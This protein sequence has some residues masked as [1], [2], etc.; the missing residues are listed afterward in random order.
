MG[1]RSRLAG[2]GR[3]LGG[4]PRADGAGELHIGDPRFDDWEVVR[5]FEDL[6]AARAFSQ[7]LDERGLDS[8]LTADWP[9]DRF[10]RGDIA[11][12]VPAG[13]WIEA[14]RALDEP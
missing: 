2:I 11:L 8:V 12:R 13:S 6:D 7:H 1:L 9:L 14:E 4:T 10:G 3:A 5:D